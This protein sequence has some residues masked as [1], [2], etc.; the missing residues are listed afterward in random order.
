MFNIKISKRALASI[1]AF[2][3]L[4]LVVLAFVFSMLP[5]FSIDTSASGYGEDGGALKEEIANSISRYTGEECLPSEIDDSVSV[6]PIELLSSL[7]L[8]GKIIMDNVSYESEGAI[9]IKEWLEDDGDRSNITV[10]AAISAT[11]EKMGKT[12]IGN[13]SVWTIMLDVV[14]PI[15][16]IIAVFILT[17]IIPIVMLIKMLR[18]LLI[19]L[20]GREV[21]EK[22][23]GRLCGSLQG[24][25]TL[26]AFYMLL[27][28]LS[29]I[30]DAGFGLVALFIVAIASSVVNA[31][32]TRLREYDK[33]RTVYLNTVQ[34]MSLVSLIG[35]IIFFFNIISAGAYRAFA[36]GSFADY[37]SLVLSQSAS[38][39]SAEIR[40]EYISDGVMMIAY[41]LLAVLSVAYLDR[42]TKRLSLGGA[43]RETNTVLAVFAFLA[44][45]VPLII[46][47][48]EHCFDSAIVGDAI[49]GTSFLP[50]ESYGHG[51]MIAALVGA[52]IMLLGEIGSTLLVAVFSKD[53]G[54]EERAELLSGKSMKEYMLSE[55]S[56]KNGQSSVAENPASPE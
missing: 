56:P 29:Q 3:S 5:L 45:L 11:I 35:F 40:G 2:V 36:S 15:I 50:S 48:M 7:V 24:T 30:F 39:P 42:V 26:L 27:G 18:A 16:G 20:R 55:I 44:T 28:C 17:F 6:S 43:R 37:T 21:P 14:L 13:E 53:L 19:A 22:I 52:S 32:V 46:G 8:Y 47:A 34:G 23:S 25:F 10:V 12:V 51:S 31:A 41:M 9:E 54:K 1:Q 4:G 49:S 33:P 38:N